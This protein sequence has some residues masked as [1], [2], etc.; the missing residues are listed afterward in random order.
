MAFQTEPPTT[1]HNSN[2]TLP[3]FNGFSNPPAII[4]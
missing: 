2:Q 1:N 4:D 3:A